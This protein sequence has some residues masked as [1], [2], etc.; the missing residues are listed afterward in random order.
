MALYLILLLAVC[1]YGMKITPF[2]Q[3]A[4]SVSTTTVVKGI[5][6]IIILFSHTKSYLDLSFSIPDRAFGW[7]MRYLGQLMV[8]PYF[9]YSGYGIMESIRHK[10]NYDNG[11]FKKRILKTWFHFIL[12]VLLFLILQSIL[13][14]HFETGQYFLCW[15]AWEDIGNSSWFVFTILSLYL[16]TYLV[17]L[18]K[19]RS[20]QSE[21]FVAILVSIL[22]AGLWLFLYHEKDEEYWWYDT[23]L[24]FPAGMWFSLLREKVTA[25]PHR[26]RIV[27]S[28]LVLLI[29][30][31][32]RHFAGIDPY[33]LCSILFTLAS[34][35]VTSFVKIDNAILQWLGKHCFAIYILQRIPM[36]ALGD[37][38]L[39]N[40]SLL[41]T[42]IVL[43]CSLL[44]AWVFNQATNRIDTK[45]F[46]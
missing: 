2:R 29:F 6:A 16:L 1:C 12:A 46:A 10:E 27:L 31:I 15:I 9:F 24:V 3:D 19:K 5:F 21:V 41:F 39:V 40:K 17:L 7:S 26:T 37:T 4:L 13:G 14:N 30:L 36:I 35:A 33:G 8:A 42:G 32:W 45:L 34:T 28:A 44:L 43:V 38:A 23:L 20:S 11:F 25:F 18:L 22:T